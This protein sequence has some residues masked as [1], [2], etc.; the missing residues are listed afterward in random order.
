MAA[1]NK[2]DQPF[3]HLIRSLQEDEARRLSQCLQNIDHRLLHLRKAVEEYHQLRSALRTINGKLS[4]LGAEPLTVA[5]DVGADDLGE[6]ISSRIA[7][8][9][10]SGRI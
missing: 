1:D 4:R 3:E 7:H 10:T 5:E 8:F 2:Q 9:K 6:I